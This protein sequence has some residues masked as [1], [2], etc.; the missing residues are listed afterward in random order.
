MTDY[1]DPF[2]YIESENIDEKLE[3]ALA[4]PDLPNFRSNDPNVVDFSPEDQLITHV[5]ADLANR[6]VAVQYEHH[7]EEEKYV[8]IMKRVG[9][10]MVESHTDIDAGSDS[11]TVTRYHVVTPE[12]G[13]VYD[14]KGYTEARNDLP[15]E[16]AIKAPELLE[17]AEEIDS[18]EDSGDLLEPSEDFSEENSS[19]VP[20][21]EKDPMYND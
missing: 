7:N 5:G 17:R 13:L 20:P 2:D 16:A 21:P 6:N 1:L 15:R 9:L 3:I 19:T 18:N 11:E 10:A 12:I 4:A 8:V 14:G